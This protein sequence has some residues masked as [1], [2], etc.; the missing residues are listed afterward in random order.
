MWPFEG[1]DEEVA[2]IVSA[3]RG[4]DLDAAMVTAPAGVGKTRLARQ[5]AHRLDGVRTVWIGATRAAGTIPFGALAPLLPDG[6]PVGGPLNTVLAAARQ[7]GDWGGRHAVVIVVDDAHLLDEGSATVVAHLAG[8]RLGFVLMTAR[9]G[10]PVADVLLRLCADEGAQRLELAPLP[11]AVIDRLIAHERPAGLAARERRRLHAVA[12]GNPLAL[13]E[14]LRG[15]RPGGLTDLVMSRLAALD[16]GTR[17]AV[18]LVACGEPLPVSMLERLAGPAAAIAA[19]DAGLVVAERSGARTQARLGHPLYGEVLRAAMDPAGAAR[20]YGDL[21]GAL[22]ATALRRREDPLRAALWQVEAGAVTRAGV[23]REGARQAVGR[24]DLGLAE[25]LARAARAAEPGPDSDRL[26]AEILAYRGRAEEA[27]R[28]L[29]APAPGGPADRVAWAITRADAVYWSGGDTDAALST[30]D[31][32]GGHLTAE[33]SRAWLQCFDGRCAD[34]A[35][36]AGA[37]LDRP[38]AE[39]RAVVW[40]ATAGAAAAGFL[41]RGADAGAIAAR[42]VAVAAAHTAAIPWG[43]VEVRVGA[44]LAHL[45]SGSPAAATAVSAEGYAQVRRGGAAMMVS[46]W[47]LYGGL[48]ALARGHL[49]GADRLLAEARAGFEVDDTFRLHRHCLAARAAVA[50]LRGDR[51]AA[52]LTARADTLA[53]PANRLFAPWVQTWRA[54]SHHAAGDHAAAVA[55]AVRA[56]DLARECGMPA[57]EALAGYDVARLG[58]RPDL[59]RLAAI[60]HEVGRL[61]TAAARALGDRDGAGDLEAAARDFAERGYDLHAAEA[62]GVAAHRHHRHGRAALADLATA[63]AAGIGARCAGAV[64]P[65]LRRNA[66]TGRLTPRE[67]QIL[68]LAAEHT[69]A[70]IA[71]SL[72]LAV[73]TVNN[74]LARAYDKLGIGS[75]DELRALLDGRHPR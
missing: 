15:A 74:N 45:A 43:P 3:F 37:V 16:P 75:R 51:D 13:S 66:F 69:S 47:A 60:D 4:H 46:G 54:W 14:L 38:E 8:R 44:C 33:A 2:R 20:V 40:A 29:S 9:A 30:L 73:A 11:A 65:L 68:L 41:G 50:A 28:L 36:T 55:A 5:V 25:R 21:A 6:E 24:E 49:D 35:R 57:V 39:P 56:A 70:R 7:A 12:Q 23:V 53:H 59:R 31:A 67:R 17:R 22:L 62:Y 72:G 10:E 32:A 52:A 26:L 34:A 63:S 18:E 27:V 58:G 19:E 71:E 48:A 64:T 42:G 61:V 1:R